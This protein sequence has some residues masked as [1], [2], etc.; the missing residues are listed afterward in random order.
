MRILLYGLLILFVFVQIVLKKYISWV[1]DII[2]LMVVFTGVFRGSV[3]GAGLGLVAGF[4]RGCFSAGTFALDI[5]L[6]PAVGLVSSLLGGMF[7]RQ[8]P[9]AQMFTT[10][11]AILIVTASHTLYLNFVYGNDVGVFPVIMASWKCL[12]TTVCVSPFFFAFL[13]KTLRLKENNITK[14]YVKK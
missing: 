13:K 8:N 3:E 10:A 1:P 6:F 9:V 14:K 4:F 12:I 7:Y 2:L 11:V 5:F